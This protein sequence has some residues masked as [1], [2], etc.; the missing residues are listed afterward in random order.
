MSDRTAKKRSGIFLMVTGLLLI[1]AALTITVKNI[2]EQDQAGRMSEEIRLE[3]VEQIEQ[4]SGQEEETEKASQIPVYVLN[5]E[6]EMPVVE[7]DGND[8]VGILSIEILDLELPVMSAWSY[9]NLRIA[10]CRYYGS[11]YLNNMVIAAHNYQTHFG[12]LKY[13][14]QGDEVVFTDAEGN[15]FEYEVAEVE[16]LMPYAVED[17]TDGT[18][19][20]TLFTCTV[21]G[22][23]RVVIRCERVSID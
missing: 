6:M 18:W 3:L 19:D 1:A 9:P 22:S 15:R 17:M 10:P 20:L 5:P 2:Y 21:G 8:Y 7:I 4:K 12:S 23:S 11:V 16:N 13:L 14:E